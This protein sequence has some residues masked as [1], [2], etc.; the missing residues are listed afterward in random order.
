MRITTA[1]ALLL[2][3]AI[4]AAGP[5][6]DATVKACGDAFD[7][8]YQP[9]I[10]NGALNMSRYAA[11][12][13]TAESAMQQC[14]AAGNTFVHNHPDDI[15]KAAGGT[16]LS[17]D[18]YGNIVSQLIYRVCLQNSGNSLDGSSGGYMT[19]DQVVGMCRDDKSFTAEQRRQ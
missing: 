19:R 1:A 9:N 18:E 5:K 11:M 17:V 6:W 2:A 16:V 10:G 14:A 4:A 8:Y 13:G 3:P 12:T 15:A 7:L